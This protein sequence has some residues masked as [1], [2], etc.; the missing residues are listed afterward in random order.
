ME[1]LSFY[2]TEEEN[3]KVIKTIGKNFK[4]AEFYMEAFDPFYI[5][6]CSYI[7]KRYS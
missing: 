5:T 7:K 4:D 3:R 2:L 6:M 1:G